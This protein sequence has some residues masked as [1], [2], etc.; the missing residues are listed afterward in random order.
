MN[1]KSIN[2]DKKEISLFLSLTF[3]LFLPSLRVFFKYMPDYAILLS[4]AY[5]IFLIVL[6]Y[7]IIFI[8][9]KLI[10]ILIDNKFF[11]YILLLFIYIIIW[12]LYPIADGLKEQMRGS[13]Q[14]DC[15][16][17]GINHLLNFE[18]PY[19]SQSYYNN[20]CSPGMGMLIAYLPFVY[21]DIYILG[22]PIVITALVY[23]V[24][25]LNNNLYIAS[26]FLIIL[27]SSIL[28]IE[29]MVVGSDLI[30]IGVGLVFLSL[31]LTKAI[32]LKNIRLI[33]LVALIA[34]IIGSTRV[35]FLILIFLS[36][37]YIY[38]YWKKGMWIFLL[39]SLAIALIPSL[40]IYFS[41]PDLF[42]P[43]HLIGKGSKLLFPVLKY[44]VIFFNG[45][46]F[47]Y[48][49]YL[50][51]KSTKNI[52]MGF[53]I[54]LVPTLLSLSIAD[55]F[56]RSGQISSWEGANY[57]IPLVPLTALLLIEISKKNA[58]NS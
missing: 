2:I 8:K 31:F 43:L 44:L 15:V 6:F 11:I 53:F 36:S 35:N 16:I 10:S 27:L 23:T 34:G 12:N 14:D 13:D 48:S 18:N 33:I 50:V 54:T 4:I 51:K 24:S 28:I 45:I 19:S 30:F 37:A 9:N 40:F 55:L 52:N 46:L 56:M 17:M 39:F 25:K 7:Q 20:P 5:F 42:S 29:L 32:E 49:L 47:I 21:L 38:L 3:F 26:S 1:I 57:L 41:N 22:A 58:V